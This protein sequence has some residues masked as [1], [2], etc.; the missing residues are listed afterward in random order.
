M[1]LPNSISQLAAAC[2]PARKS[3]QPES[4]PVSS[5]AST[6]SDSPCAQQDGLE[7]I[8]TVWGRVDHAAV[9]AR[10]WARME[11]IYPHRWKSAVGADY[12]TAAGMEWARALATLT[13]A[14]IREGLDACNS[15]AIADGSDREIDWP[16]STARFRAAALGVPPFAAIRAE[17]A[18]RHATRSAFGL[19]VA[20]RLDSWSFRKADAR[21]AD[22]MLR[23]AYTAARAYRL[24]GGELPEVLPALAD[25]TDREPAPA[26]PEVAAAALS[27]MREMLDGT[28]PV[29]WREDRGRWVATLWTAGDGEARA[30][31]TPTGEGGPW[32]WVVMIA[33]DVVD[34][35]EELEAEAAKDCALI[36]AAG[37]TA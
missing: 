16:P 19:L 27:A 37:V 1:H 33:G 12:R 20:Q 36:C 13:L 10:F 4:L 31:V 3:T 35:G 24:D 9:L 17:F 8:R 5:N 26:T 7:G 25:D 32:R 18:D 23:G 29:Q 28:P 11:G 15:G 22:E 6:S 21:G 34:A 2:P 30:T 14:Q